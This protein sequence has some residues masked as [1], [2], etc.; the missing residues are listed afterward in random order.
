MDGASPHLIAELTRVT[1][2]AS[3]VVVVASL[4]AGAAELFAPQS[5]FSRRGAGWKLLGALLVS[6]TIHFAAVAALT[7]E[8]HAQ[9]IAEGG[10]WLVTGVVGLFF[11]AATAGALVLRRAPSFARTVPNLVGDGVLSSAVALAFLQAYAARRGIS[12]LFA[13]LAALLSG[14]WLVFAAAVVVRIVRRATL[15]RAIG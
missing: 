1:A 14:A 7:I 9:N 3:A 11:Y 4:A 2:R 12:A 5:S 6:H 13:V 10:G 15:R 8:R